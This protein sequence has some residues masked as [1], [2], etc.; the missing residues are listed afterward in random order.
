MTNN[1]E[2]RHG[3]HYIQ[4]DKNNNFVN[5]FAFDHIYAFKAYIDSYP[6]QFA[7]SDK[8]YVLTRTL[9]DHVSHVGTHIEGV[10]AAYREASKHSW[11]AYCH[12]PN[13][14]LVDKP[15]TEQIK[16][17]Y[18]IESKEEG[19]TLIGVKFSSTKSTSNSVYTYYARGRIST[20]NTHAVVVSP[21][22]GTV[23]VDIVKM[24]YINDGSDIP[25]L[26]PVVSVFNKKAHDAEMNDYANRVKKSKMLKRRQELYEELKRLEAGLDSD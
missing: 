20:D 24:E 14:W 13:G 9:T 17:T 26:K 2:V 10:S 16:A 4:L 19:Y 8:I 1:N 22:S 21:Y 12:A 6:E 18:G 5:G 23:I 7:K 15:T 25:A 3:Y 11:D